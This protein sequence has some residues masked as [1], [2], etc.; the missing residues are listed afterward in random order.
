MESPAEATPKKAAQTLIS[1]GFTKVFVDNTIFDL[2]AVTDKD[3]QEGNSFIIVD[4]L[5]H[6]ENDE[7]YDSRIA[8][9]IQT[10]FYEGFGTCTVY[11][12][13]IEKHATY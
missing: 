10:S 7:N 2:E 4:R 13:D 8:D 6:V 11:N 1:Q 3:Y 5:K 9:S 12:N